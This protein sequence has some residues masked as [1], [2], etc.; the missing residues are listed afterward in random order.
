M[1]WSFVLSVTLAVAA[2]EGCAA[3]PKHLCG[4]IV[5]GS[6][7]YVGPDESL[8]S[9][10]EA[11]LPKAPYQTNEG[12]PVR[13]VKHVWYRNGPDA[14]LACTFAP[15]VGDTCSVRT[16]EF[17]RVG[18]AWSKGRENAVLCNVAQ[19]ERMSGR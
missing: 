13:A 17:T 4:S 9:L 16:T 8:T 19:R 10:H 12:K 15:R 2:L 5:P 11:D 1:K 3:S 18:D 6:W 7:V 14:L